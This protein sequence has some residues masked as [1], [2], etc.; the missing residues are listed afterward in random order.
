[1][2]CVWTHGAGKKCPLLSQAKGKLGDGMLCML[3]GKRDERQNL[4]ETK[5]EAWLGGGPVAVA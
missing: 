5:Q 4:C 3:L 2:A 1:L